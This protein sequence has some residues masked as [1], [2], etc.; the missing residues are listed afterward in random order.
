MVGDGGEPGLLVVADEVIAAGDAEIAPV[1]GLVGQCRAVGDAGD[2]VVAAVDD[3][4]RTAQ[5]RCALGE[6]HGGGE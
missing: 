5:C 1:R 2:V 3:Q 4:E 6:V